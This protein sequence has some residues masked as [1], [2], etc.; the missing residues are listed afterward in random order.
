MRLT[1]RRKR[2]KTS[3]IYKSH[4]TDRNR[5]ILSYFVEKARIR[6]EDAT[7]RDHWM[8]ALHT[9]EIEGV[10]IFLMLAVD[11]RKQFTV[12]RQTLLF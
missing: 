3:K 6:L 8:S 2:D 11:N 4:G 7:I 10:F 5:Y 9:H 1:H 12:S